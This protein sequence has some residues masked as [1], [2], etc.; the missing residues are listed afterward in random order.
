MEAI[1]A[2]A[3]R[4]AAIWEG[5]ASLAIGLMTERYLRTNPPP[6]GDELGE[7][8]TAWADGMVALGRLRLAGLQ[9][10]ALRAV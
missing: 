4:E 8:M 5:H 9:A 6:E 1:A 2:L 3:D 10:R 7:V